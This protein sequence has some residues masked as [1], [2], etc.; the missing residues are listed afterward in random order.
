MTFYFI[1]HLLMG[2][3]AGNSA[4]VLQQIDPFEKP[5]WASTSVGAYIGIAC[6]IA[7]PL[8]VLTTF[9]KFTFLWALLT[10][11]ELF[12]GVLLGAFLPKPIKFFAMLASP[13][14]LIVLFGAL[15]G[16]WYLG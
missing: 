8:A 14:I 5:Y 7:L 15:W 10:A 6:M 13:L 11:G 16:W 12:L 1:V 9:I 3:L 4:Y 2:F